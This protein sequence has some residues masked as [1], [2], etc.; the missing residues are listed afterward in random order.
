MKTFWNNKK[1]FITGHTGFKG[2]WLSLILKTAGAKVAGYSL[3]PPTLPSFFEIIDRNA[4]IESYIHDIRDLNTLKKKLTQS[5]PEIVFHLAA[6]SLVMESYKDP[7]DTY[8]TN[9]IGTLNLLEAIRTVKSVR[10]VVIITTDKCYENKEWIWPYR[11]T[12][13]LGGYDPYSSSKACA[14]IVTASMRRAFFDPERNPVNHVGIATARAGNVIGGGDWAKDRLI[15][16]FIRAILNNEKIIIRHPM[17]IRPWQHVFEPLSG[18]MLLAEKLFYEGTKY[19][20]A[21]NFGPD[22]SDVRTVEWIINKL[23]ELWQSKPNFVISDQENVH[24]AQQLRLDCSKARTLLN[25]EPKWSLETALKMII[26]WISVY[27]KQGDVYKIC[28]KQIEQ[29]FT[30]E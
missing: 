25:W 15:P 3:K 21:W 30:E 29:F 11:E 16:D 23:Y 8:T 10:S 20:E 13:P 17:A 12:D 18:Y 26:E 1:V 27:K 2:G 14:E 22:P 28:L 19:S 9:V 5:S 6:Q 7:V 4:G 24:E